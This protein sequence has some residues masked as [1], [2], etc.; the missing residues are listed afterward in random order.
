MNDIVTKMNSSDY[1]TLQYYD[2]DHLAYTLKDINKRKGSPYHMSNE[3]LA[4]NLFPYIKDKFPE[5]IMVKYGMEQY[6][7]ITK[8]AQNVLVKH[9]YARKI[10]HQKRINE[11][12]SA[13]EKL[14]PGC[15]RYIDKTILK[16]EEEK[17]LRNIAIKQCI[18]LCYILKRI[19]SQGEFNRHTNKQPLSV[20]EINNIF[21]GWDDFLQICINSGIEKSRSYEEFLKPKEENMRFFTTLRAFSENECLEAMEEAGKS[22]GSSFT[23]AQYDQWQ[24]ENKKYPTGSVI[25]QRVGWNKAK[26]QLNLQPL[27]MMK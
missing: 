5:A 1:P 24:K 15:Y 7:T 19:P 4:D 10:E 12:D 26:I 14:H 20:K 13:I 18:E 23:M 2:Q 16:P 27:K 25:Q 22:L 3:D 11:I 6:I 17:Y 9:L 21:S 8:R